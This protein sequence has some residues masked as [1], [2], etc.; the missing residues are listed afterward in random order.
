MDKQELKPGE[1][2]EYIRMEVPRDRPIEIILNPYDKMGM[3]T[4]EDGRI[5]VTIQAGNKKDGELEMASGDFDVR[6]LPWAYLPNWIEKKKKEEDITQ[7]PPEAIQHY[8]DTVDRPEEELIRK[9]I[10][11]RFTCPICRDNKLTCSNKDRMGF[12]NSPGNC[13]RHPDIRM[14]MVESVIEYATDMI[15]PRCNYDAT[16]LYD[17]KRADIDFKFTPDKPKDK[18]EFICRECKTIISKFDM[19]L[20]TEE[21]IKY[22]KLNGMDSWTWNFIGSQV[23][24]IEKPLKE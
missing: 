7:C 18:C 16:T 9:T 12:A 17:V 1:R 8:K 19:D 4:L 5:L 21:N 6:L 23:F 11:S 3:K 14:E 15:C 13:K 2:K 20:M 22:I 24:A 10:K